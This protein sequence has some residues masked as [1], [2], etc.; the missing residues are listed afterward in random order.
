M[1]STEASEE[2]PSIT[3][4]STLG[5]PCLK[6]GVTIEILGSFKNYLMIEVIKKLLEA[7]PRKF[8]GPNSCTSTEPLP[9]DFIGQQ[10]DHGFLESVLYISIVR[11][12]GAGNPAVG[13]NKCSGPSAF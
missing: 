5:Y 8:V 11:P 9:K 4:Y 3:I 6:E 10:A 1:I 7:L 2:P 12:R 13:T